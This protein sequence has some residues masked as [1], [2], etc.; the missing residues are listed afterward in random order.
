MSTD[1]DG[2]LP[3]NDIELADVPARY[4]SDRHPRLSTADDADRLVAYLNSWRLVVFTSLGVLALG[5]TLVLTGHVGFLVLNIPIMHAVM[6]L[7]RCC[8]SSALVSMSTCPLELLDLE[9]SFREKP[10]IRFSVAGV[11]FLFGVFPF[12]PSAE[13]MMVNVW[14]LPLVCL[15]SCACGWK[16]MASLA[17]YNVSMVL[18]YGASLCW[19]GTRRSLPNWHGMSLRYEF[20]LGLGSFVMLGSIAIGVRWITS[21]QAPALAFYKTFYDYLLVL[22][23]A[24]FSLGLMVEIREPNVTGGWPTVLTGAGQLLLAL[25]V[26]FLGRDQI[27]HTGVR[28]LSWCH[29]QLG[30]G[31]PTRYKRRKSCCICAVVG[32]SVLTALVCLALVMLYTYNMLPKSTH[33]LGVRCKTVEIQTLSSPGN[34]RICYPL[35]GSYSLFLFAHGDASGGYL[36][37]EFYHEL[38]VQMAG[39]GFVVA[40]YLSC[41]FDVGCDNG[42]GS[43][44]EALKLIEHLKHVPRRY[45]LNTSLPFTVSGHSTGGRVALVLGAMKDSADYL[46]SVGSRYDITPS[47]KESLRNIAAVVAYHPDPMDSP[48]LNPDVHTYGITRTPVFVLT[49]TRDTVEPW[50]SAWDDF[51]RVGSQDKIFVNTDGA[52]HYDHRFVD[53]EVPFMGSFA[54]RHALGNLSEGEKVCGSLAGS[55]RQHIGLAPAG[56]VNNGHGDIAFLCCRGGKP[57]NSVLDASA[58]AAG[59]SGFNGRLTSPAQYFSESPGKAADLLA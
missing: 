16:T 54:R 30:R 13:G 22:G 23:I 32:V 43:F 37:E 11:L 12:A 53:L 46:V 50:G 40:S 19:V 51:E 24:F 4:V 49:G 21:K 42:R 1:G 41:W 52:S 39:Q 45:N 44:L 2:H 7:G 58:C 27:Y 25:L 59:G 18:C 55:L 57:V 47:M 56:D 28:R 15:V 8:V 29:E 48:S 38:Q 6:C 9:A 35:S 5:V 34:A 33:G 3:E 10:L 36:F 26:H 31:G 14:L 17:W 20:W